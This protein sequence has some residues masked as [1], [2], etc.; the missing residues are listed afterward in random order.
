MDKKSEDSIED[1]E[2]KAMAGEDVSEFY[3]PAMRK[4]AETTRRHHIQMVGVDF[5]EDL[6]SELDSLSSPPILR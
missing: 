5:T 1:I 4:E 2:D 6:L 3:G